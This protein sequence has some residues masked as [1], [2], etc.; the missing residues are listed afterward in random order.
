MPKL[1]LRAR[2]AQVLSL[3]FTAFL[4]NPRACMYLAS[5]VMAV[6]FCSLISPD[7]LGPF[8]LPDKVIVGFPFIT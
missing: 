7:V 4:L 3:I 8:F 1:K 2:A 6:Y 5:V